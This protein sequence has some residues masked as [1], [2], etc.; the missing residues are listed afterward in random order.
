MSARYW[1]YSWTYG[2]QFIGLA[3]FDAAL[4]A[5]RTRASSKQGGQATAIV[6]GGITTFVVASMFAALAPAGATRS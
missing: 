3:Q 5:I 4:S 2:D 1:L 6:T